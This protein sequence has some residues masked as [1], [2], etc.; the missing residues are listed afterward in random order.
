MYMKQTDQG[1][2]KRALYIQTLGTMRLTSGDEIIS[3]HTSITG[4]ACQLF[5]L[6]AYAGTKGITRTALQDALYD[7]KT[8]DAANALRINA[9]RLRKLLM[10]SELPEHTYVMV[11]KNIYYLT[12]PEGMGD[13]QMDAVLLEQLWEQSRGETD[14]SVRRGLLEK[15]CSLYGGEFFTP[16]SGEVWVEN[17]RGH[18]QEI[19]F[20]C[21]QALC[22]ILKQQEDYKSLVQV[23]KDA[24]RLYPTEEWT[25][26]KMD[27]FMGMQKYKEA[28]E[29]YK[30][31]VKAIFA[32]QGM[33]VSEQMWERFKS[34]RQYMEK[35]PKNLENIKEWLCEKEWIPGAYCCSYPGFIDCYRMEARAAERRRHQGI[36]MVCTI[37]DRQGI[38]VAEEEKQQEYMDKLDQCVCT[39][40]RRSDIYTRYN[41]EQILILVNDLKPEKAVSVENRII[42]AFRKACQGK[43]EV[44]TESI[45]LKEWLDLPE[46]LL[47]AKERRKKTERGSRAKGDSQL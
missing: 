25:K 36:L 12:E 33:A 5:L 10:Q 3:L 6:L 28:V 2:Q 16:L 4:K 26:L 37:R 18:F 14:V 31:G 27:G 38:A 1:E 39:S 29:A 11:D 34:L 43:A 20:K 22:Q 42:A 21:V 8:T 13:F 17:L 24:M 40:L 47:K 9:S 35:Q 7:R 19:Y 44:Q 30:D 46:E 41:R 23:T 15:A 32:E 45:P